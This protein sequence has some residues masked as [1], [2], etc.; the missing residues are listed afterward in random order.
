[1][2]KLF[3]FAL[4]MALAIPAYSQS[5]RDTLDVEN[6]VDS[7][8]REDF[9]P[10]LNHQARYG[11][12]NQTQP[13]DTTN[14]SGIWGSSTLGDS[15]GVAIDSFFV[16]GLL[17]RGGGAGTGGD[18]TALKD[19]STVFHPWKSTSLVITISTG[20]DSA[21]LRTI[22][23]GGVATSPT[24]RKMI[25]ID[26]LD[27]YASPTADPDSPK[28]FIWDVSGSLAPATEHAFFVFESLADS[29]TAARDTCSFQG[30]LNRSRY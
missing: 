10:L 17:Q 1:M 21:R 27:T 18:S 13:G 20:T 9:R 6:R 2:K 5:S 8:T 16:S 14:N 30:R 4:I 24:S 28:T 26:T 23:M 29:S 12:R 25:P 22:L 11:Y 7:Y 15:T 19:S 3:L